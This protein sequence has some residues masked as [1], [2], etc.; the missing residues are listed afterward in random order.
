M[1]TRRKLMVELLENEQITAEGIAR[2]FVMKVDEAIAE[3]LHI[4]KTVGKR[5]KVQPAECK[6]C[7]F[8]FQKRLDKA[9]LKT[10]SRCPQCKRERITKPRFWIERKT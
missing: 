6:S 4:A 9:K 2:V 5:F 7:G 1:P 8:M 10:P 3:L